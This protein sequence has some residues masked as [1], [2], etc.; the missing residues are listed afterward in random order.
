MDGEDSIVSCVCKFFTT[1]KGRFVLVGIVNTGFGWALGLLLYFSLQ[2]FVHIGLIVTVANIGAILFAFIM[3][4][5]F[6]FRSTN[7]WTGELPKMFVVY[8]SIMILAVPYFTVLVNHFSV[9]FVVA[10][11][12][13]IVIS[14]CIG[15]FLGKYFTFR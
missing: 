11:T 8:G 9:P 15:F 3:Q 7:A 5:R 14:M 4:K 6:V 12:S 13:F 1:E 2:S 10:Q